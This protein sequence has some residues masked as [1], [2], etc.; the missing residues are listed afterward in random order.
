MTWETFRWPMSSGPV[1][2]KQLGRGREHKAE[3]SSSPNGEETEMVP[4]GENTMEACSL[5]RTS[6]T[7]RFRGQ[8]EDTTNRARM[9]GKVPI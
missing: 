5:D 1:V 2:H 7:N 9:S 4:S 6:A 8:V 3:E